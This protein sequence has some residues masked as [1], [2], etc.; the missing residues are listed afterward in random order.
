MIEHQLIIVD[1]LQS[2]D[3]TLKRITLDLLYKMTNETNLEVIADKLVHYLKTTTNKDFKQDLVNKLINL[4]ERLAPTQEWF[5]NMMNV[6]L[7]FGSEYITNSG[8][9]SFIKLILENFTELG[10]DFGEFIID[11]YKEIILRSNLPDNMMKIVAFVFGEIG[12]RTYKDLEIKK[13]LADLLAN[14][15]NNQFENQM[16]KG[17]IVSAIYKLNPNHPVL[18]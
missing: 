10:E 5:I 7:E 17:T 3:E 12:N 18:I 8:L 13:N 2:N 4:N 15:L 14:Q 1:C 16:T 6:V 9:N 11:I